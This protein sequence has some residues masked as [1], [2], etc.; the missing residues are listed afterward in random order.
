MLAQSYLLQPGGQDL[1]RRAIDRLWAQGDPGHF[2]PAVRGLLDRMYQAGRSLSKTERQTAAEQSLLA[3]FLHAHMDEDTLDC[4]RAMLC[5][6]LVPAAPGRLIPACTYNLF[7]RREDPRFFEPDEAGEGTTREGTL[8][9]C[10][11]RDEGTLLAC[12]TRVPLIA[13]T[14][15]GKPVRSPGGMSPETRLAVPGTSLPCPSV[16]SAAAQ[17][18]ADKAVM[19]PRRAAVMSPR[20]SF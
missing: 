10:P 19:S 1:F 5:P 16:S 8:L 7:Y 13:K 11:P 2:L 15:P 17:P 6:D 12:P 18:I 20:N 14:S 3:V 9:A 4:S